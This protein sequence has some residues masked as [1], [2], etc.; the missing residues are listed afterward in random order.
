MGRDFYICRQCGAIVASMESLGAEL[1]CN[2]HP[3]ELLK[4][5]SQDA[6]KEKHV[7]DVKVS[8]NRVEVQV[9]SVLHPSSAEHYIPWIYLETEKGGQRKSIK[10]GEEP[11][12]VFE[13]VDDKPLR[14]Y[15]YCNLHGLWVSEL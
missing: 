12:A 4:A 8:G 5:G 1:I 6:S 14:V 13:L 11:K 3:M 9:G 15:A 10:P 7:P 2:G